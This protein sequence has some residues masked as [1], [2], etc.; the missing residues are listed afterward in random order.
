MPLSYNLAP[1]DKLVWKVHTP[2]D[3]TKQL[4]FYI[5]EIGDFSCGPD[6][7]TKRSEQRDYEIIYTLKGIGEITYNDKTYLLEKDVI[8]ILDCY[9]P[10]Y[11][12]SASSRH[13]DYKWLHFNGTSADFYYNFIT[14]NTNIFKTANAEY[15]NFCFNML[16]G[17]SYGQNIVTSFTACEYVM[18]LLTEMYCT[19]VNK[20]TISK[21]YDSEIKMVIQFIQDNYQDNIKLDDLCDIAHLSKYYFIGVFKNHTGSSPYEYIINY[22]ISKSKKLL[23]ST[24]LSIKEI[25]FKVGFSDESHFI[26]TFRNINNITPHKYRNS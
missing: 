6:F 21:S 19:S 15:F 9:K 10:H 13:W 18:H 20:T 5:N 3:Q 12:K 22:R 23:R 14:K 7:Y 26:K 11:Y 17:L 24:S 1:G 8:F 2:N 16:L 25:A 4:P